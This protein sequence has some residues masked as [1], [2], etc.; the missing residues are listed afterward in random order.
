MKT[1]LRLAGIEL[2]PLAPAA[3]LSARK[4]P[5]VCQNDAT[6]IGRFTVPAA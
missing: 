4:S 3:A 2:P 6:T 1:A 5:S